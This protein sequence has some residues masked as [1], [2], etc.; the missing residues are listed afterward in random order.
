MTRIHL[1]RHGET[2]WNAEGRIQ[3]HA[4]NAL[5]E[6]GRRQALGLRE[7]LAH[8]T[9]VRVYA[10]TSL[11]ARETAELA[12]GH[13][14]VEFVPVEGLREIY[15]ADWEGFL[16]KEIEQT[17]PEDVHA[18]RH[19][20]HRFNYRGAETFAQLQARGLLALEEIIAREHGGGDVVVVSHGAMI[21]TLLSHYLDRPL[22]RLWEPPR[23]HNCAHSILEVRPDS[24]P[25]VVQ[26]ADL[27][28]GF[29]APE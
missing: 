18:F 22:S 3:G 9:P 1:I 5:N 16:Y 25:R 24:P 12:F 20:P 11:R 27:T 15:L 21:R 4:D 8:L 23:M 10:S 7:A 29:G 17:H 13:L 26:Y 19:E 14:G 6:L 2:A 28:Q